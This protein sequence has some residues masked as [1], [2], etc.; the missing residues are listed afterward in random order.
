MTVTFQP[1]EL[2]LRGRSVE[3]RLVL[4]QGKLCAIL[5][6][7]DPEVDAAAGWFV[8]ASFGRLDEPFNP[9][10]PDLE[11]AEAWVVSRMV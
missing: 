1:I 8:E 11:A 10:F 4:Y 9:A 6:L 2:A 5:S 3:A 7:L